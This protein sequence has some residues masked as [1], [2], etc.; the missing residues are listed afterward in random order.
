MKQHE[1]THEPYQPWCRACVQ[2]RAR[3][4]KHASE[5]RHA[6]TSR[7]TLS[8]DFGY[9]SRRPDDKDKL[10][11][12]FLHDRFSKACYAIP[13][14]RKGGASLTHMVT[15]AARFAMWL[16]H[17]SL[18]LRCD[19]ENAIV[20]LCTSLQKVLRGLGVDVIRDTV[21]VESHQSNGPAEQV[22]EIV[23]QHAAVLMS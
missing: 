15:E 4:D 12:L 14:E 1:V 5:A 6:D 19:N 23:R 8:A 7:P 17:K 3:Q 18:Q 9:F 21:L 2:F 22:V 10:T 11:C 13:T 16:G 20:A